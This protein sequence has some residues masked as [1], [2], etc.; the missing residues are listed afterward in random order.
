MGQE[1]QHHGRA[2]A[3][4][5][6]TRR[7]TPTRPR[8][9]HPVLGLPGPAGE[10]VGRHPEEGGARGSLESL[11]GRPR[12]PRRASWCAWWACSGAR[13]STATCPETSRR[14]TGDDWVIKDEAFAVWV[15]GKKPKGKGWQLDSGLKRDTNKW[16]SVIGRVRTEKRNIVYT[17]RPS[18]STSP[19]RPSVPPPRRWR[20]PPPKE[21]PKFPPV[22]VFA[23]PLDG[24]AG[25][26]AGQPLRG[27]VQQGHGRRLRSPGA[28]CCATRGR[29][30]PATTRFQRHPAL[31]RRPAGAR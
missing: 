14:A 1:G 4:D 10:G 2:A 7:P 3:A 8:R 22:I 27:A 12:L 19:R 13:T 15:S 17:Q 24:E 28:S 29:C 18:T 16:L 20:R 31:V 11:V 6:Q 9:R 5:R 23:M 21:R 30:C 25:R 26:A